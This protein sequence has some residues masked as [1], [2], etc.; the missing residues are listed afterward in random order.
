MALA[1]C[2]SLDSEGMVTDWTIRFIIDGIITLPIAFYGFLVF[3]DVPATSKAFYLSKKASRHRTKARTMKAHFI[4]ISYRNASWLT[5]GLTRTSSITNYP[6]IYSEGFS[7]D[8]DGMHV[9]YW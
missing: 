4:F 9:A 2:H 6:G 1:A 7:V 3:P 5:N 8:G